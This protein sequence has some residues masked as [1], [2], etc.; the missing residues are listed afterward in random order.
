MDPKFLAC[1]LDQIRCGLQHIG[2]SGDFRIELS[3]LDLR[4]LENYIAGYCTYN[5]QYNM[6]T[7]I[8]GVKFKG[9]DNG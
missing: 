2:C 5:T 6:G 8:A 3:T 4:I 7:S 9:D 1:A